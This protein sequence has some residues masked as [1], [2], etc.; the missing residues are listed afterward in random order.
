MGQKGF[1]PDSEGWIIESMQETDSNNK[2]TAN[3]NTHACGITGKRSEYPII[4]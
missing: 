2:G 1:L 3:L 4:Q